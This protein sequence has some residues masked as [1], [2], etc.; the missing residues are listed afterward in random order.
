MPSVGSWTVYGHTQ[1]H[2]HTH[3]HTHAHTNTSNYLAI[4]AGWRSFMPN[5]GSAPARMSLCVCIHMLVCALMPTYMHTLHDL[6]FCLCSHMA[7][8]RCRIHERIFLFQRQLHTLF[9]QRWSLQHWYVYVFYYTNI[10]NVALVFMHMHIII[11][12][13]H[14]ESSKF[15]RKNIENKNKLYVDVSRAATLWFTTQKDACIRVKLI[16]E[17][18]SLS[19]QV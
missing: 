17:G 14:K 15:Q 12:M 19:P 9:T 3:T 1:T 18:S 5:L 10:P 2:T 11:M 16:N 6:L 7:W 13:W 8:P 4:L